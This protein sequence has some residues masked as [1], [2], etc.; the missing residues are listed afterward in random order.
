M[1]YGDQLVELQ[2]GR[3][4]GDETQGL[5]AVGFKAADLARSRLDLVTHGIVEETPLGWAAHGTPLSWVEMAVLTSSLASIDRARAEWQIQAVRTQTELDFL[6]NG[7]AVEMYNERGETA[8]DDEG[9]PVLFQ[10]MSR[11]EERSLALNV[12]AL[13]I[14][15]SDER[16]ENA[17]RVL[18]RRE[19][20]G[21]EIPEIMDLWEKYKPEEAKQVAGGAMRAKLPVTIPLRRTPQRRRTVSFWRG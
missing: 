5:T 8:L 14:V 2:G 21:I 6:N 1:E 9:T 13:G 18:D 11:P 19:K 12:A 10:R 7:R 4:T 17:Q 20:D 15:D 3:D 16:A